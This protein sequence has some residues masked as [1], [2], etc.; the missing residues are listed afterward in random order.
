[1]KITTKLSLKYLRKNNRRSIVTIIGI[2]I[3]TVLITSILI[4]FSSYQAYMIDVIRSWSNWEVKYNNI[5]YARAK[6]IANNENIKEISLYQK[7][8]ISEENFYAP[9]DN[10]STNL[11][12]FDVRAYDENALKNANL[13]I[14]EGRLP[15]NSSEILLSFTKASNDYLT[16]KLDI[17][18]EFDLTLN[19]IKRNYTIVRNN[20]KT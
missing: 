2:I 18:T 17:G 7:L 10:Q 6:D 9:K 8:G 3:V 19:G 1:M 11:L 5:T 20:R 15:E 13:Y 12:R 14:T 4:L 16:K